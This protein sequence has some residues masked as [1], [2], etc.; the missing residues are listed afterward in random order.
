MLYDHNSIYEANNFIEEL[1]S[2][3]SRYCENLPIEN[4][5][6]GHP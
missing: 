1:K 5:N 2:M 3:P 4:V 6:N